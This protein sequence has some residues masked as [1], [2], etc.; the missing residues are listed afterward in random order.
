[1]CIAILKPK[2]VPISKETLETC[3]K[4]NPDGMGFAYIDGN[5]MYIKKYMKFEDFYPDF[6]KVQDK[7]TML[8]HFR[9]ATH[10]KV[11]VN[12]C[13]PFWL[14]KRMALVHNG[15]ISGYGNKESKSDTRDFIDRVIGKIS[16]KEMKNP[17]YRELVGK[18]IGYSKFAI[19]DIT[20]Q[21]WIINESSGYWHEGIWYSNKSY[22][23]K[24]VVQSTIY[25]NKYNQ[26]NLWDCYGD[27][28]Y[29]SWYGRTQSKKNEEATTPKKYD[30]STVSDDEKVVYKCK[31]CGAEFKENYEVEDPQCN[32]CKSFEVEDIGFEYR[33]TRYLY[34]DYIQKNKVKDLTNTK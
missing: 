13:H 30:S 11:E 7:S 33:G 10:G 4:T 26:S 14:N 32:V 1:M 3:C 6:E 18:A 29:E 27:E 17:A 15:I 5:K 21:Y 8:I 19:L 20:G 16:W 23:P 31:K 2:G 24:I 9:I 12:N 34:E 28:D 25:N 22:E